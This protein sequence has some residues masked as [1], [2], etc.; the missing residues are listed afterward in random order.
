MGNGMFKLTRNILLCG[1]KDS[2]NN[3][4]NCL[5]SKSTGKSLW[6]GA[7]LVLTHIVFEDE[8]AG[9]V[10]ILFVAP[11]WWLRALE[12]PLWSSS[13]RALFSAVWLTDVCWHLT[14][15]ELWVASVISGLFLQ[16]K[17]IV[18]DVFALN[19]GVEAF[20]GVALLSH[21]QVLLGSVHTA[22]ED[23]VIDYTSNILVF[24]RSFHS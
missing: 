3:K 15:V 1:Q 20:V 23:G 4:R 7:L 10:S 8:V 24:S 17:V 19:W 6:T 11:F 14:A 13:L 5:H 16:P 22:S 9:C 21:R 12:P 2:S 18:C